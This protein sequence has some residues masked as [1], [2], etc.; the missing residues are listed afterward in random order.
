MNK[1]DIN[2]RL[3]IIEQQIAQCYED[4]G[5]VPDRILNQRHERLLKEQTILE[6]MRDK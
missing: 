5:Y 3:T 4:E 2:I 6:R 1:H